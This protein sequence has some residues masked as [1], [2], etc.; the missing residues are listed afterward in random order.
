VS[1]RLLALTCL[2]ARLLLLPGCCCCCPPARRDVTKRH[3]GSK[4]DDIWSASRLEAMAA[5][6]D[7]RWRQLVGEG[8]IPS[9][10]VSWINYCKALDPWAVP[11]YAALGTLISLGEHEA[12]A[13]AAAAKA[14]P[15][16]AAAAWLAAE[17]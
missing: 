16:A 10:L 15:P 8:A 14:P 1:L 17:E 3:D 9:W 2:P 11:D 6:R 5:E 4:G 13:A 7:A 12:A